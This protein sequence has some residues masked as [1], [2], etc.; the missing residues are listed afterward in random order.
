MNPEGF[1][2]PP[3]PHRARPTY[4]I[5]RVARC[6]VRWATS[7]LLDHAAIVRPI[8]FIGYPRLRVE[9]RAGYPPLGARP[10]HAITS[11][12]LIHDRPSTTP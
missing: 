2:G 6:L 1:G 8:G 9:R 7:E 10:D 5:E 12:L 4:A 3:R 11:P